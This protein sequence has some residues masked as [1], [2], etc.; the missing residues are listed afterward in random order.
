MPRSDRR[1]SC[2]SLGLDLHLII[3]HYLLELVDGLRDRVDRRG[4]NV[5]KFSVSISLLFG[6]TCR[7]TRRYSSN[8]GRKM[9]FRVTDFSE[10]LRFVIGGVVAAERDDRVAE[11]H[12]LR[13]RSQA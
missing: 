4:L 5:R 11:R 6:S 10:T 2:R 3:D 7:R 8:S 1:L 9:K 12:S 13:Q